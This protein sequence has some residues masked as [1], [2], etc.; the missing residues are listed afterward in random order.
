MRNIIQIA[1]TIQPFVAPRDPTAAYG[2]LQVGVGS[3]LH[4]PFQEL[5][6]CFVFLREMTIV[7]VFYVLL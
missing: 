1:G 4:D 5:D 3:R 7:G 2:H 6:A